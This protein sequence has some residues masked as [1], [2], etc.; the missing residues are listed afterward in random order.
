VDMLM[1]CARP[2]YRT[3]A[4]TVVSMVMVFI[5][6]RPSTQCQFH[7]FWYE[8]LTT[9]NMYCKYMFPLIPIATRITL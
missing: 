9:Q 6:V 5:C 3:I 2:S 4:P 8:Q 7:R 1:S